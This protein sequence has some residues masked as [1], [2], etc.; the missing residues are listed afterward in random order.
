MRVA[1]FPS[2]GRVA[3]Y[4]AE[5]I[6]F[7]STTLIIRRECLLYIDLREIFI[8]AARNRQSYRARTQ[9]PKNHKVETLTHPIEMSFGITPQL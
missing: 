6:Y 8:Y 5:A 3:V 4:C 1:H 7:E 2:A 9:R